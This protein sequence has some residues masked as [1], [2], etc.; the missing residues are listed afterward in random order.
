MSMF[1]FGIKFQSTTTETSIYG[2]VGLG[3]IPNVT[4]L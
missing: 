4:L 1:G 3:G 2:N